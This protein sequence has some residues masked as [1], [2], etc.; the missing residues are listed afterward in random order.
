MKAAAQFA[1]QAFFFDNSY[2]GIPFTLS[3]HFKITGGKKK[4]DRIP[5][6][7]VAKWFSKYYGAKD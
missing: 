5:K 6:K 3:A 7:N 2:E 1:Y 4:W